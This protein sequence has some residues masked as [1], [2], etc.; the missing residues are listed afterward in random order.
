MSSKVAGLADRIIVHSEAAKREIAHECGVTTDGTIKV[1]H[2]GNYHSVYGEVLEKFSARGQ[3]GL[4]ESE[5]VFLFLGAIRPHKGVSDLIAAFRS[6]GLDA[7]LLIAGN[8]SD[9]EFEARLRE[10]ERQVPGIRLMSGFIPDD[11]IGVFLSSADLVVLPY[12]RSLTSGALILA[13]TFARACIVPDFDTFTEFIDERG[14]YQY[15]SG[16]VQELAVVMSRALADR[17]RLEEM[18]QRNG[19]LVDQWDWTGVAR[20]TA[21]V[22][23]EAM[24]T[25]S[26]K[27]R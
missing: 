27:G 4:G 11:K 21:G 19:R 12:Q 22:Y 1:V 2:H 5:F 20:L 25:K 24:M 13:M 16:N 3:L 26:G 6:S 10:E 15:T 23:E 9:K 7:T 8:I 18:G 14:G 17:D